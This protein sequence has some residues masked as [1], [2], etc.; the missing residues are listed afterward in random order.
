VRGF[1]LLLDYHLQRWNRNIR[2][3]IDTITRT[4]II[5][6][7][8]S[9]NAPAL[10]TETNSHITSFL[11]ADSPPLR[12]QR[13]LSPPLFPRSKTSP[14]SSGTGITNAKDIVG[15]LNAVPAPVL[16]ELEDDIDNTSMSIIDG[17]GKCVVSLAPFLVCGQ[18]LIAQC[19]AILP[20]SSPPSASPLSSQD[21]EIDEL[22]EASLTPPGTPATSLFNAKMGEHT[23]IYS[24]RLSDVDIFFGFS[25][26]FGRRSRDPAY[27]QTWTHTSALPQTK[28]F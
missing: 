24:M 11:R 25:S 23:L 14:V 7:F 22:W 18:K 28:G 1:F 15:R 5:S 13:P 19:V 3:T 2:P 12:I 20:I 27:S 16:E 10:S 6:L 4:Y 8:K 9:T 26:R 21:A 17:W